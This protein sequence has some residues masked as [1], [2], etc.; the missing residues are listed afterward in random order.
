M[1]AHGQ[2]DP[3]AALRARVGTVLVG[4]WQ[5]DQLLGI[6]GSAAVYAATH[7][8]GRRVAI[9]IAHADQLRTAQDLERFRRE[10]Y[11]A[12]RI[13]HPS[14]VRVFDDGTTDEGLPF[15]VMELL[16]GE[17][18]GASVQRGEPRTLADVIAIASTLLQVLEVAHGQGIVHRDLKPSNFFRCT[19]GELKLLDFGIARAVGLDELTQSGMML[20]TPAF[21]APEQALARRDLIGPQSDIFAI[22]ASALVLLK[23]GP[24]REGNELALAAIEPLPS[25]EALGLRGPREVMRVLERAVAFHV[26]ARF[27]D[28]RSMREALEHAAKDAGPAALAE[29]AFEPSLPGSAGNVPTIRE[30]RAHGEEARHGLANP[31]E[32]F[33]LDRRISAPSHPSFAAFAPPPSAPLSLPPRPAP[34][35]GWIRVVAVLLVLVGVGFGLLWVTQHRPGQSPPPKSS[36]H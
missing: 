27:P 7:R 30:A 19:S 10:P 17:P 2:P 1:S 34:S 9:K 12:N 16:E 18:V 32:A 6:G 3:Y 31:T 22:G 35:T 23:G 25:A 15:F 8:T 28:A 11:I 36:S 29:R 13:A 5:L 4:K 33:V 20:G 21:M 14:V 24:L 26:D